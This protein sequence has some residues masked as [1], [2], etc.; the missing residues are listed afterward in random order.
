[1]TIVQVRVAAVETAGMSKGGTATRLAARGLLA[2]LGTLTGCQFEW[3]PAP[4]PPANELPSSPV[5]SRSSLLAEGGEVVIDVEGQDSEIRLRVLSKSA[6]LCAHTPCITRLGPGAFELTA[7][8]VADRD[9]FCNVTVQIS[10]KPTVVRL[11]APKGFGSC[12][13]AVWSPE[14][15]KLYQGEVR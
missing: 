7:T 6:V 12:G 10:R 15:G 5:D 14:D 3:L 9:R 13:A 11:S 4:P 8:S 1:M 2:A